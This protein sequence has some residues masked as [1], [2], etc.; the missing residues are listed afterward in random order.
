MHEEKTD[1][2]PRTNEILSNGDT[3]EG[4]LS[5]MTDLARDLERELAM[6]QN[7]ATGQANAISNAY[8]VMLGSTPEK[9]RV[10]SLRDDAQ[11][12]LKRGESGETLESIERCVRV[13]LGL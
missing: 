12:F 11:R 10:P 1:E 7:I 13:S 6:L 3:L 9:Y 4:K 8:H 2:T 5:D